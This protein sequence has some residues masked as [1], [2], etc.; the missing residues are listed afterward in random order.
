MIPVEFWQRH[1]MLPMISDPLRFD[2]GD[3]RV[4]L[5]GGRESV[6][7]AASVPGRVFNLSST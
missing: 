4:S 2:T 5:P 7:A 1:R 6:M 3:L